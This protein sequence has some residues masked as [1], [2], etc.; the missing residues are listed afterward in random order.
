M[1]SIALTFSRYYNVWPIHVGNKCFIIA[2]VHSITNSFRSKFLKKNRDPILDFEWNMHPQY[3]NNANDYLFFDLAVAEIN[4]SLASGLVMQLSLKPDN[5]GDNFA[6]FRS[7]KDLKGNYVKVPRINE[8]PL[9]THP[10]PGDGIAPMFESLDFGNRGMS[11][12]LL[13]GK[14]A[15]CSNDI[16]HFIVNGMYIRRN[17]VP[18]KKTF[19]KMQ[20][21]TTSEGKC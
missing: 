16:L 15:T 5:Y 19:S 7:T 12:A 4:P 18:E 17:Y 2:P 13:V 11:G 10:I 14:H 3:S 20:F 1:K 6:Y 21:P 9:R 8:I